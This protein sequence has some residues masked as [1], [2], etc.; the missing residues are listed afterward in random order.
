MLDAEA[1]AILFT[2]TPINGH[3]DELVINA[4]WGLGEAI[5]GGLVT[6]DTIT[7]EKASG[8]IKQLDTALKAV[9]TVPTETGTAEQP[10]EAGR[11]KAQVLSSAQIGELARLGQR[12]ETFYGCPQDI[13]WCLARGEFAILQSRPI[14]RLPEAEAP[15]PT[16]W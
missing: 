7:V 12:L 1:A 5:V 4:A 9:M 11:R 3:R 10:V 8:K 2:A 16:A 6:P 15:V 13:E 14:T